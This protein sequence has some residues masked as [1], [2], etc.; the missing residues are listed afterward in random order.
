[1]KTPEY[2]NLPKARE[3]KGSKSISIDDIEEVKSIK[4]TVKDNEKTKDNAFDLT[5][6]DAFGDDEKPKATKSSSMKKDKKHKKK[7]AKVNK[8][9]VEEETEA[10]KKEDA[11]FK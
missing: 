5:M 9:E 8:E 7:K 1:M 11:S 6:N 4:R 2:N 3:S 10:S